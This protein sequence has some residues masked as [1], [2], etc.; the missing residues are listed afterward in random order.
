MPSLP[1]LVD[2]PTVRAVLVDTSMKRAAFLR[3][4]AA[5]LQI[6]D[7]VDVRCARA[8]ELAHDPAVRE[9]FDL[10]VARGF[11]SA[12]VTLECAAPMV[13]DGGAIVLAGPPGGRR[14]VTENLAGLGLRPAP[15]FT[16]EA[17][18]DAATVQVLRREGAVDASLPR[19]WRQ[20]MKRPLEVE[21]AS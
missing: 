2:R 14:W 11:A 6:D 20:L 18:A 16:A 9:V 21:I 19:P 17:G 8:E 1:L 3:W 15:E 10:A 13:R 5:E 7:R 4:A 12:S